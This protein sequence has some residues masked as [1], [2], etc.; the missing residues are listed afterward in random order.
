MRKVWNTFWIPIATLLMLCVTSTAFAQQKP[1]QTKD[2]QYIETV[3]LRELVDTVKDLTRNVKVLSDNQKELTDNVKEL[4]K[5]VDNN[6]T[7]M[8][9]IE[10]RMAVIEERTTWIRGL[11]Y[12]LLAAIVGA[13]ATPIILY[14][15]S[16]RGKQNTSV[17]K[18]N[19]LDEVKKENQ[20]ETSYDM[21]DENDLQTEGG[22]P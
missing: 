17:S 2:L 4:T 16:N 22:I 11:L 21:G 9:V 7:R 6:N 14:I 15:L 3:D 10:T 18:I 19:G 12:I 20:V 1:T 5:S 8:A 13:I